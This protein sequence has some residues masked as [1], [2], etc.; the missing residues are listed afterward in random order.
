MITLLKNLVE[1]FLNIPQ[2]ILYAA[3]TFINGWFRIV[4]A[5]LVAASA[6]LGELPEVTTPPSYIGEIN[7]FYPVGTMLSIAAPLVTAYVTWL[8]ISYLYRKFGAL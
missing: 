5:A 4:E 7:W 1:I 6:L 3:E 2:Y 8:G